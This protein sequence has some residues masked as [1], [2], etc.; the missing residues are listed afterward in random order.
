ME[1]KTVEL[2]I[3]LTFAE[4]Y[5]T[6]SHI[7]ARNK[8][9]NLLEQLEDWTTVI[10]SIEKHK[11]GYKHIHI[12]Y[13]GK[14]IYWI[15]FNKIWKWGY[16]KNKPIYDKDGWIN[17]IRKEEIFYLRGEKPETLTIMERMT[18]KTLKE[19]A[20]EHVIQNSNPYP[21]PDHQGSSSS[22]EPP[23]NNY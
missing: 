12:Y 10:Y 9:D 20:L 14:E 21:V 22:D 17:Y 8:V 16:V 3:T 7:D 2:A 6:I 13:K 23:F 11:N 1:K 5:K 18:G 15:N 19:A 4:K